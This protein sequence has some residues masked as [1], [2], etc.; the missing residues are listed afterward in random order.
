M[1]PPRIVLLGGGYVGLYC[2]LELERR[3][4][5]GEAEVV[6]VSSE[7]FM[8]YWPLLV[9]VGSGDLDPRHVAVP[10]RKTL[11]GTEIVTGRVTAIDADRRRVRLAPYLGDPYDLEFH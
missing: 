6:L 9:E 10:L 7:N 5:R 11:P 2:A 3:L 1:T 8:L 4:E